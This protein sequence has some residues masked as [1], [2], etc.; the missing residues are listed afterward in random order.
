MSSDSKAARWKILLGYAAFAVVAFVVGLLVTFPYDAIRKRLVSEAAQAGLAVRIGSLR[1]G[2]AGI[3]ATNV[4]VSKPPQP[5]SADTVAALSRGEGM[6][7]AAELG[8]PL[9]LESVALRPALF[10]PGIAMRASVMGGTLSASVGLLGDTRVKVTADG[11][12]ASGGNLPAFTGLDLDGEL[13]AALSLTMP[14][15]GAQP[16][17]SQAN[18]ELTLD[19]RNLVIKG[20]KVAIPMGGGSAVPMDLP[21]IDL[22]A[23]TGRIQFVKGLGTVESLRLKSN[24]LEALATGTLKLGK[25]LEYS[26]PGMDV[27]IK[28][29]PEFQKR[30]G[31]VG[32]GVTILPPDK[33]DPSFRA[34]RL[35]GFLNRPTF[36]P[37]R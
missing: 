8:E 35:A 20:G 9:V 29:D 15:N 5:L 3:T 13:N 21:Q 22:G 31:L 30:L 18:G 10:P 7:G 36:L 19:T 27:N 14:K 32:A 11:L 23:L 4:R 34:A 1:P 2:L 26:E 16:D 17:L 6:L 37:R 28:L 24:E 12:Q 25:R 33:K